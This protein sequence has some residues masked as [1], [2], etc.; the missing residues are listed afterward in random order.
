VQLTLGSIRSLVIVGEP[1]EVLVLNP[2]HPV[3]VLVVVAL[4]YPLHVALALLLL[5]GQRVEGLLLLIFA[6]LVPAVAG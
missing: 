6:H 2:G 4:L 3:F 1:L 5:L